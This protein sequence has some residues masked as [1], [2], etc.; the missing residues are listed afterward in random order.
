MNRRHIV[1]RVAAISVA[2]L[3]VFEATPTSGHAD[4]TTPATPAGPAT[5][6]P[7]GSVAVTL[8]GEGASDPAGELTTWQNDL[9]GNNGSLNLDYIQSGGY[10]AR[11][12][13]IAGSVDYAISGVPFTSQELAKLPPGAGSLI[14]APVMASGLGV[15]V[16]PP[17]NQSDPSAIK[18]G[19]GLLNMS[20]SSNTTYAPYTGLTKLPAANLAAMIFNYGQPTGN[21]IDANIALNKWN[22]PEVIAAFGLET[23]P[24]DANGN[25]PE[26]DFT[27][28]G[29]DPG[30]LSYLR[31]DPSESNYYSELFASTAAPQV[32]LGL[33]K[34]LGALAVGDAVPPALSTVHTA[35]GLS[36]QL[37]HLGLPD[38]NGL[39][40]L[41]PGPGDAGTGSLLA[42]VPPAALGL[43]NVKAP[44]NLAR[45]VNIQNA[46]GEW[47]EPSPASIDAAVN[48]GGDSP[49][50]GLTHHVAGA[51]PLSYVNHFYAPSHGLSVEKTE[52]LAT[53]IR[54]LATDGQGVTAAHGDGQLSAKL[55]TQALAAANQLVLSNCTGTGAVLVTSSD[56]GRL[57]P[58][59]PGL[60]AIGSMLHC[61]A[62]QAPSAAA[63]SSVPASGS[64]AASSGGVPAFSAAASP[65]DG[66]TPTAGGAPTG[67]N[68]SPPPLKAAAKPDAK[69]GTGG[70][71]RLASLPLSLPFSNVS[72]FDRL[73]ALL[74]GAGFF[75]LGRRV[76]AWLVRLT[77]A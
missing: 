32:W 10:K 16:T 52:A 2:A 44:G 42:V 55:V 51:Y 41:L 49:F 40:T 65:V 39:P 27:P 50:F 75:L 31:S 9:F 7:A 63:T 4:T 48:A 28:G 26:I 8:N 33:Q 76:L 20:A 62:P 12:D 6:Q 47:V 34:Q 73:T 66:S 53:A 36:S 22:N 64:P 60:H 43:F 68:T 77:R 3:F 57:A 5:A 18:H 37:D 46:N 56:P 15:I 35:Q 38:Q 25:P 29:E 21:P 11:Q 45:W 61:E 14:D 23:K 59:L 1:G 71:L 69:G 19:W 13:L 70:A 24:P 54:Y 58:N 74:L 17:Y 72:T 30:P 67:G